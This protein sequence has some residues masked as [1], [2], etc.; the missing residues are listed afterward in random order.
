VSAPTQEIWERFSAQLHGFLARRLADP[1]DADDLLQE[2]FLRVHTRID[3][4]REGGRLAPWVYQIARNVLTDH[5]RSRRPTGELTEELAQRQAAETTGGA[6]VELDPQ[7][8]IASYLA[9]LVQA[10]PDTYQEAV[11]LAELEGLTQAE[12]ARRLGLSVSGA[13]S[14]VQRGRRLLRAQLLECC[15]FEFDLRGKVIDYHPR[16]RCCEHCRS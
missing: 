5:Y 11:R 10:L 16:P 9:G 12:V 8:R 6:E 3:T 4:L 1:H 14:R 13:K 2:V 7:Q 15:H